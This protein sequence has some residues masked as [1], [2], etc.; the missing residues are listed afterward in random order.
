[1]ME[2]TKRVF[3]LGAGFSAPAGLPVNL[4]LLDQLISKSAE[5]AKKYGY[6]DIDDFRGLED[7]LKSKNSGHLLSPWLLR[8]VRSRYPDL[9]SFERFMEIAE[10]FASGL[11]RLRDTT[12]EE[13]MLWDVARREPHFL[14]P[15]DLTNC[16]H[17]AVHDVFEDAPLGDTKYVDALV[18]YAHRTGSP[19]Y[20]T[21]FD[22]LIEKSCLNCGLWPD[23]PGTRSE[24]QAGLIPAG[25]KLFKMHGSLDW[26]PCPGINQDMDGGYV[27]TYRRGI[28]SLCYQNIG[29]DV[30]DKL[31]RLALMLPQINS[32]TK[33][34]IKGVELVVIGNDLNDNHLAAAIIGRLH[35][36]GFKA[37]LIN[38]SPELP[39]R[40]R[41][42]HDQIKRATAG[43]SSIAHSG[44]SSDAYCL[45]L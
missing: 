41:L 35:F 20:T 26:D 8:C 40:L 34:W 3:L 27:V 11:I 2:E 9:R 33:D 15:S 10:L 18:R 6:G 12:D 22:T 25:F 19:I 45:S 29:L 21:N 44:L 38:N 17:A 7:V 37:T 4:K 36:S 23:V 43:A 14:C 5:R 16:V 31:G 39:D 13:N 42:S 1:M 32:F 24:M 28:N 30:R